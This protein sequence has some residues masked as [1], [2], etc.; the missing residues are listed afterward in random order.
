LAAAPNFN[1]NVSHEGEFV[2]LASEPV[3]IVGVDVAAPGQLRNRN[4][5]GGAPSVEET[6]QVVS[7][8]A[9]CKR[10]KRDSRVP[11]RRGEGGRVSTALEL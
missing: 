5:K 7:G 3:C 6:L 2:V 10:E 1:F 11:N 9:Q 8:D 4:R